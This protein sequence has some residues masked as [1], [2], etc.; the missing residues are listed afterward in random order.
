MVTMRA[1]EPAKQQIGLSVLV[2]DLNEIA[3]KNGTSMK[4]MR[5]AIHRTIDAGEP[6]VITE[7]I[8]WYIFAKQECEKMAIHSQYNLHQVAAAV[9]HLSPRMP[10][11]RNISFAQEL[12]NTGSAP[13]MQ[14]SL[15]NAKRALVS[16]NPIETFGV[17]A[18]KT[19]NFY[20][21]L[22]GDHTVVTVD[23]W[24]ARIAMPDLESEK[25]LGRKGMYDAVSH[26]YKL[27]AYD[28][29]LRPAEV[30]AVAW[31]AARGTHE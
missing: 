8:A 1:G 13:V 27:A 29:S 11:S 10:W 25:I 17:G 9:A 26:A 16:D 22:T 28:Y 20:R 2:K 7:G 6:G 5:N 24:A 18:H 31:C 30:Q 19:R 23:T 21:N 14:R 3:V 15:E 4:R 12:V